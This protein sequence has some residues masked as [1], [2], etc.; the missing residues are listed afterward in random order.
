MSC[1]LCSG[2]PFS[3]YSFVTHQ[4]SKWL[5]VTVY[6]KEIKKMFSGLPMKFSRNWNCAA[7]VLGSERTVYV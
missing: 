5:Q 3:K 7:F 1:D 6:S 2:G 4:N